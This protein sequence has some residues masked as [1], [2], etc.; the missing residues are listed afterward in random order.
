[1]FHAMLNARS[2]MPRLGA[3]MVLSLLVFVLSCAPANTNGKR[4][5]EK[6]DTN[7]APA[8]PIIEASPVTR[9]DE[10][11]VINGESVTLNVTAPGGQTVKILYRPAFAEGRHIELK[12]L[13]NPVDASAG[14]F[15]TQLKMPS[16]FTGDVWAEVVYAHGEKKETKPISLTTESASPAELADASY[17]HSDE[18]ARSDRITGGRIEQTTLQPGQPDIRITVN[19]PAFQLTL[20]QNGEEVKTYEIGIGKNEYPLP[21]GLRHATQIVFNPEWIPPDSSWIEEHDVVPG[22]RVEAD[23]PRNPLG[24]IKVPL[25]NGIL[26]HQ[27]FKPSDVGHLV[28]HGCVRLPLNDVYDLVDKIIAARSLKVSKKQLEHAKKTKD[29]F[30]IKLD[31]PLIVDI[32]YDTQVVEGGALHLYP[33]VYHHKTNTIDRVREELQSVSVDGSN[34]SDESLRQMLNR[35][36][37]NEQFVVSIADI[38]A[39]RAVEAGQN[40]PL[41]SQSP[42]K[43]PAKATKSTGRHRR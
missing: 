11:Q 33:D 5:S 25:G 22:E 31:A 1:M 35:V 24:K 15:S 40:Q 14:K 2:I 28:S 17:K 37:M 7:A 30:V 12:K 6:A 10:W 27:A 18:S 29:R 34:L 16:D 39:G 41:T 32:S 4:T 23:D 42:K 21:D 19:I 43:Q 13:T 36:N 3:L 9:N 8:E 26:I 38:N 20:W